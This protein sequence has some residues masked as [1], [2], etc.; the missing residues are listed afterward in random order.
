MQQR[1]F[2]CSLMTLTSILFLSFPGARAW[3]EQLDMSWT[4]KDLAVHLDHIT[5]NLLKRLYE[6]TT[7]MKLT[8]LITWFLSLSTLQEN[9]ILILMEKLTI[10]L[11]LI[12]ILP[13]LWHLTT[14]FLRIQLTHQSSFLKQPNTL[15]SDALVFKT[16]ALFQSTNAYLHLLLMSKEEISRKEFQS[17]RL[18]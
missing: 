13:V 3:P 9:M 2:T 7:L 17:F 6:S 8:I 4:K 11:L 1:R 12:Q 18:S 14:S 10:T 5:E 15:A 16:Q